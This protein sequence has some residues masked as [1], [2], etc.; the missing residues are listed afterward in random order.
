MNRPKSTLTPEQRAERRREH[1]R[2]YDAARARKRAAEIA[3]SPSTS[4]IEDAERKTRASLYARQI[5][6]GETIHYIRPAGGGE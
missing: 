3:G 1:Q 2:K 4:T 5:A 6:R